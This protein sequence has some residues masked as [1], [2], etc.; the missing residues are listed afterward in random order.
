VIV[1]NNLDYIKVLLEQNEFRGVILTGGNSLIKYGGDAPERDC[2]DNYL[3]EWAIKNG[4]PL[5]GVCRGMQIIQAYYGNKLELVPNHV[6][7]RHL[8]KVHGSHKLT[9]ILEELD[10]VNAFHEIGARCVS[11]ELV[12]TAS[13]CDGVVMSIEH[14]NLPIYGVMWHS[15][16]ES[17]FVESEKEIFVKVFGV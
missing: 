12:L 15:E 2:V 16:R 10:Y 11:G 6:N 14:T 9:A 3:L 1:P 5:L 17:P 4:K 8:L 7:T 13:S